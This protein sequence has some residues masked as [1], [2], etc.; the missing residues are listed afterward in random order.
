[1]YLKISVGSSPVVSVIYLIVIV[2][3]YCLPTKRSP[4]SWLVISFEVVK[5]PR[6]RL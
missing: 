2:S 1:M 3:S 5:L 4:V 6:I